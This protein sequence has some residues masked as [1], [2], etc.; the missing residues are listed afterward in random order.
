LHNPAHMVVCE[1]IRYTEKYIDYSKIYD[2]A[3]YYRTQDVQKAA[4]SFW[5]STA[6]IKTLGEKLKGI[7]KGTG[8]EIISGYEL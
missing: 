6:Q 5:E 4:E 3:G 8:L 7:A 2:E 1:I